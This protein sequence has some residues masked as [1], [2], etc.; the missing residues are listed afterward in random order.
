MHTY[1]YLSVAFAVRAAAYLPMFGNTIFKI[2]PIQELQ[3]MFAA[4]AAWMQVAGSP[5]LAP[6]K[7]T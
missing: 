2:K 6:N 1:G 3:S 4:A 5:Y 7:T